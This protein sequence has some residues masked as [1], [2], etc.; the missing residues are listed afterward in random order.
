MTAKKKRPARKRAQK[1]AAAI[2]K[3]TEAPEQALDPALEVLPADHPEAI[4][5]RAQLEE[6]I[7]GV[8]GRPRLQL[9]EEQIEKLAAFFLTDEEVASFF[10]CSADTLTRRFAEPLKRGRHFA[11]ASLKRRQYMRAMEGSDTQLIW[12]GKQ[13][14][15]QRDNWDVTSGNR[16]LEGVKQVFI[17]AGQR[18]EF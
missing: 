18:I 17:I 7:K 4:A 9:D 6:F 1:P 3:A 5:A 11:K 2:V 12:L 16:P 8:P 10:G 15:G 14:L 13:H